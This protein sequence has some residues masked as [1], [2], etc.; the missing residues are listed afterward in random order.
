MEIDLP[1]VYDDLEARCIDVIYETLKP[2]PRATRMYEILVGDLEVRANWDM[3]DYIAVVK[4][5][6]NDHGEIHA[7]VAA[8]SAITMLKLLVEAGVEPDVVASGVGDLDDAFLVVVAGALLH[9]LGNQI[10]REKHAH[11]GVYLAL[12]ILDRLIPQIYE[13]PEQRIEMRGFIL[14]TIHCH[15]VE[16]EPLTLEAGLV[17]VADGCDL[18]KG[19][20]RMA[21]DLGNINIH[22]VSALSIE[23]VLITK[24]M[25]YPVEIVVLMCNSAG[26]FQVQETLTDKILHSPLAGHVTVRATT[27]PE[28]RP[29][30][31]RIV[32]SISLKGRHFVTT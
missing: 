4:L 12:P 13:E 26:I 17:A 32:H 3:A 11:W 18:T 25:E 20:G 21:F 28:D 29:I 14:H 2:Y 30:D 6:F 8:A 16:P 24:G 19:R 31:A 5:S 9:D 10:H 22:T 7:K 1:Q 23:E 15:G 27:Q